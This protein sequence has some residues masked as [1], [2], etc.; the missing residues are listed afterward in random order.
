MPPFEQKP[1]HGPVNDDDQPQDPSR[2]GFLKK[3]L[4]TGAGVAASVAGFDVDAKGGNRDRGDGR[5]AFERELDKYRSQITA[6]DRR[7]DYFR[8]LSKDDMKEINEYF[9][10][11]LPN[12]PVAAAKTSA[13]GGAALGVV[14]GVI[15]DIN[16]NQKK[17]NSITR[18]IVEGAGRGSFVGG[19]IG[20]VAGAPIAGAAAVT[21]DLLL[22]PKILVEMPYDIEPYFS[23][24][25]FEKYK[26][27][28]QE[29]VNEAIQ[30]FENQKVTL[31]NT[32]AQIKKTT[33]A[34]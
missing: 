26:L 25:F 13:L 4:A 1:T 30:D 5:T 17:H 20:A 23:D 10:S 34:D 12:L 32:I 16:D 8:K 31:R 15:E 28:T 21:R 29:T 6:L 7:I 18:N 19:V 3:V 27:C 14:G 11:S 22:R 2:R 24:E 9:T 33:L